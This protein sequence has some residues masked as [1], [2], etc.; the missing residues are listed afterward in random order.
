[1]WA[2]VVN[3]QNRSLRG[4]P[5]ESML[6]TRVKLTRV[7]LQMIVKKDLLACV[8]R[9]DPGGWWPAWRGKTCKAH[10]FSLLV[11]S[12]IQLAD[13]FSLL[14]VCN[15]NFDFRHSLLLPSMLI[16][17][18]ICWFTI[19]LSWPCLW[20]FRRADLQR[21]NLGTKKRNFVECCTW[22][23]T[24]TVE[25]IIFWSRRELRLEFTDWVNVDTF[26]PLIPQRRVP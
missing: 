19:F 14:A 3:P 24:I 18:T 22:L 5:S 10:H 16:K 23:C 9:S 4:G 6:V 7:N 1:M 8:I 2:G 11:H 21:S 15:P 12:H 17:K 13:C 26:E 20:R 25:L